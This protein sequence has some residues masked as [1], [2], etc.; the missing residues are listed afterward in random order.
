MSKNERQPEGDLLRGDGDKRMPYDTDLSDS[1]SHGPDL[2]ESFI[3]GH[4]GVFG[5]RKVIP[6]GFHADDVRHVDHLVLKPDG[7]F[8]AAQYTCI[9]PGASKGATEPARTGL[10][11]YLKAMFPKAEIRD[12]GT[13]PGSPSTGRPRT[14]ARTPSA[15]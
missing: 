11:R 2:Y 6:R 3:D 9:L 13:H 4:Q 7:D 8:F 10:L 15:A 5:K 12:S 1:S 14:S